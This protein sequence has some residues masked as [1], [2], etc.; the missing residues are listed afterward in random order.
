ME[1]SSSS[2]R[3]SPLPIQ[4]NIW[5]FTESEGYLLCSETPPRDCILTQYSV[6]LRTT[7]PMCPEVL[8]AVD[9]RNMV[10]FKVIVPQNPYLRDRIRG[11]TYPISQ[12]VIL[13]LYI[14]LWLRSTK[15]VSNLEPKKRR[16]LHL[17]VYI[18]VDK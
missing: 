4:K 11:F 6:P 8:Q 2:E 5:Q 1:Q 15:Y 12:K 16:S 3:Y 7:T 9:R 17:F 13:Y 18:F 14:I 10:R